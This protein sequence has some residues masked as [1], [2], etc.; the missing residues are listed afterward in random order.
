MP[1]QS[2]LEAEMRK[3]LRGVLSSLVRILG[4][5]LIDQRTGEKIGK[6]F[7]LG[8]RGKIHLLGF[9]GND[10][11]LPVFLPQERL[12][13]WHQ[14]IG[15]AT[16]PGVDFARAVSAPGQGA[17]SPAICYLLLT[18]TPPPDTEKLIERWRSYCQPPSRLLLCYGGT[19][20][21]F[22]KIDYAAKIFI[23]D[24]RLRTRD[25]QRQKQS[26]SGIFQKAAAWL[27]D[28][29][30]CQYVYLA[31]FDH[32]PL[33]R[34]LGPRLIE[35]LKRENADVL[36]HQVARRDGTSCVYYLHHTHD[37]RFLPWIRKISRRPNAD[38]VLTMFGSG[39]F[40]SREAFLA[41]AEAGEPV[42]V[43][44]EMYLPTVAH[45]LGFRVRDFE[46]QNR[47]I[48]AQGDRF[49]DQ[50]EAARHGAWTLHPVKTWPW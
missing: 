27:R 43:Y 46:D 50:E 31:E 47:F 16:H 15:F 10:Q 49:G 17:A 34:D 6:G 42:P 7:L 44:L 1:A 41:V 4:C 5:T 11:V 23:D 18:H 14:Q 26:Y 2:T 28:Y 37:E 21:N 22:A 12:N 9:Q 39:S 48:S 3:F 13:R 20:E 24:P 33:T 32:W 35:R 25:H 30:E 8:W 45:H 38:V 29:P 40:W 36:G 19:K